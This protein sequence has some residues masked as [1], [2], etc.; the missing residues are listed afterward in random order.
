MVRVASRAWWRQAAAMPG[1]PRL[2]DADGLVA[3]GGHD[4][5]AVAGAG[6]GGVFAVGDVADVVECLDAPV[7]AYPSGEFGGGGLV[8]GQQARSGGSHLGWTSPV[9]F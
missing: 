9:P 2:E 8:G 3:Q 6:L 7:A 1:W 4:L 5:G